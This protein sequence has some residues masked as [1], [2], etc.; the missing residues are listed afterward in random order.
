MVSVAVPP[1]VES[2]FAKD[3]K[4]IFQYTHQTMS[5][6]LQNPDV[7]NKVIINFLNRVDATRALAK[8]TSE[9]AESSYI[10]GS[11]WTPYQC[12]ITYSPMRIDHQILSLFGNHVVYDG[13]FHPDRSCASA[14]YDLR[15]GDVLTLA[16]ILRE[17]AA[18]Q[19]ICNL[20]LEKLSEMSKDDYYYNN[21]TQTVKQRFSADPSQDEAWFFTQTGL[22]FYFAPYE[23]ASYASGVIVVE[24][25]YGK[26]TDLL[27][28]DY[29]PIPHDAIKGD[30]E[31]LPFN[32]VDLTQFSQIAEI[33]IDRN[34][35]MYFAHA[36]GT[37]QDV[38]ITQTDNSG[39]YTVFA[40]YQ[41]TPRD[42]IMLQANDEQLKTMK[43]TYVTDGKTVT[44]PLIG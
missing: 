28:I 33:V 11:N 20:V 10:S 4:V 29:L 5:L 27:Q 13:A 6:I 40:A 44:K 34:S 31:V 9:M 24:I 21:Y 30:M 39:T 38:R 12:H 36:N 17:D 8:T 35:S 32:N 37:V 23:I 16:N 22:C 2:T 41:L 25:P 19:Q 14:N 18:L 7:A 15:T 26:L 1:I 43:I 42:G 3:G